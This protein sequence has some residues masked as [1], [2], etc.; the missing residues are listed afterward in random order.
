MVVLCNRA[1]DGQCIG[2]KK[3]RQP[4]QAACNTYSRIRNLRSHPLDC[5]ELNGHMTSL[6]NAERKTEGILALEH[7][8]NNHPNFGINFSHLELFLCRW[9]ILV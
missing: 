4:N 6:Y 1:E 8:S 9:P 7:H 2:L 3:K 5:R